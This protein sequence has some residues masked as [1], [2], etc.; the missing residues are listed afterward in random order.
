ME[1]ILKN[2]SILVISIINFDPLKI[3]LEATANQFSDK[4]F[5]MQVK[6]QDDCVHK[7]VLLEFLDENLGILLL[8][9]P[10][11]LILR[12]RLRPV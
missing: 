7:F 3:T 8:K 12:S 6:G 5:P 1:K 9:V 4:Q 2:L 11:G 10:C